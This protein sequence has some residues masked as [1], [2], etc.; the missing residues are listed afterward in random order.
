MAAEAVVMDL[1][2]G[3]VAQHP[4]NVR[5]ASRGLDALAASIAEVGV[6]VPLIV[7]PVETVEGH[8]FPAGVTHV[9]IDGNR[10]QAAATRAGAVLPCI[11]RPDLASAR[12][13]AQTMAVTGLVR[14]GFTVAEEVRATQIMLDL[15]IDVEAVARATARP[16]QRVEMARAAATLRTDLAEKAYER[17]ATLEDLAALVEF[18]DDAGAVKRLLAATTN[19]HTE[20]EVADLRRERKTAEVMAAARQEAKDAGLTVTTKRPRTSRWDSTERPAL[21]EDLRS[22]Q[23]KKITALTH[24]RC[25][26]DAVYLSVNRYSS[27]PKVEKKYVCL[28]W[29]ANGHVN[30]IG[31]D[32]DMSAE[33]IAAREA[34]QAAEDEFAARWATARQV[35]VEFLRSVVARKDQPR[36]VLEW[37]LARAA[38]RD[39]ESYRSVAEPYWDDCQQLAPILGLTVEPSAQAVREFVW[40]QPPTRHTAIL[41]ASCAARIEIRIIRGAG[42]AIAVAYLE[43][44]ASLGYSLS[45]VEQEWIAQ[46]RAELA[47]RAAGDDGDDEDDDEDEDEDDDE[48]GEEPDDDDGPGDDTDED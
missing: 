5:D 42:S 14:D 10:R 37:A 16:V 4:D 25:P 7:V 39:A 18:Q 43:H 47:E 26:G 3:V 27:E 24:R 35:R 44:L 19:G 28:D 22:P 41:W 8:T 12:Q 1:D 30:T 13:T 15:G 33:D 40:A 46:V 31:T 21:L 48:D 34:E 2:P 6:L 29:E 20:Y 23:G 9:A 17:E 11:V 36:E 45:E 32:P 38:R